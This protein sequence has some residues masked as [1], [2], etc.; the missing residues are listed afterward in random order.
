MVKKHHAHHTRM[1]ALPW[2]IEAYF[3]SVR[4]CP[5]I[6]PS[7]SKPVDNMGDAVRLLFDPAG[8]VW[9]SD[10]EAWSCDENVLGR[11]LW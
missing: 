4:Q 11:E 9:C 10:G 8:G 1:S 3:M 7:Q 2:V 6:A 5:R